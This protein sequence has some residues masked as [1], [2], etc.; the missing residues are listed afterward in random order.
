MPKS[1]TLAALALTVLV[2]CGTAGAGS[3]GSSSSST[4]G[5][6][7]AQAL[8]VAEQTFPKAEQYGYFAVCGVDGNT[9]ACPYSERLK[10][11]L[12]ALKDTLMRAQ[13]PSPDRQL[14]VTVL[15]GRA[16][17]RAEL[18]GGRAMYDLTIVRA[19]DGRL[20]VDD[21]S[22]AGQESTS[23]YAERFVACTLA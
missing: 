19:A 21:E 16:V 1:L 14:T 18:F 12:A 20:L 3:G 13:T 7:E 5:I 22:C 2:A 10:T 9:G 4:Q 6:T 17:V 11:R 8:A 23:I 15:P